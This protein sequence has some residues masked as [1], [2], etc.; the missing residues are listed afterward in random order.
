MNPE[1]VPVTALQPQRASQ[2]LVYPE[3][4]RRGLRNLP[5]I[6]SSICYTVDKELFCDQGTAGVGLTVLLCSQDSWQV[7]PFFRA[8]YRTL[9]QAKRT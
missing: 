6:T 4:C 3:S 1:G 9:E 8:E 2:S 5:F 7:D